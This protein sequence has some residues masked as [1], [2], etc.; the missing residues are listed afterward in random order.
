MWLTHSKY[1]TAYLYS[2][3]VKTWLGKFVTFHIMELTGVK[4][5]VCN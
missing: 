1:M 2:R 5:Y 4:K 3:E